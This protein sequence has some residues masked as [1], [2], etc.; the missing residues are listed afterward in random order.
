MS[1]LTF[2]LGTKRPDVRG[3]GLDRATKSI[4]PGSRCLAMEYA[5]RDGGDVNRV[6]PA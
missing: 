5:E 4:S 1:C 2:S 3:S 6:R